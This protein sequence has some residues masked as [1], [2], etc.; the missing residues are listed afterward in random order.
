MS[1]DW[2]T[3]QFKNIA[4]ALSWQAEQQPHSIAIHYPQGGFM[5]P[6]KYTHKTYIE[7]NELSNVYARGLLEYGVESGTRTALMLTPGLDFIAM[8]FAMFKA[9]IIPVLVDPGIGIKPL[10]CCLEEAAPK[11]FIGITKAQLARKVLGWAKQSCRQFVTAG[12]TLGLGGI[13]LKTLRTLGNRSSGEILHLPDAEDMAA[14]LFTSGSTGIPKGVVYRHRHFSA[15]VE[16]LKQAFN[17]KPGEVGLPT[18]PPF[19]LFDPALGMTTVVPRMD[20][21]RPAKANPKVLVRTIDAF[22]VNNIFGSPALLNTLSR[23]LVD[24]NI[25]LKSVRRVISAGAAVPIRVIRR[26]EKALPDDAE[27]HTPYGA[28]ECLPVCSISGKQMTP[29]IQ[30]LS[31]SGNGICVGMPVAPNRV[32]IIA[33][34]EQAFSTLDQITEVAAGEPGEIIVSGPSCTDQYWKREQQ[35]TL[36]K[37]TDADGTI[38]HRMGDAGSLDNTGRL[39]YYGRVTQRLETTQEVLFA[40]RCEAVFNPHPELLRSALVGLGERGKQAPV[41]CVELKGKLNTAAKA[42]VSA[43]LLKIAQANSMTQSIQKVLFHKGFPVDIRHNSKINR[44][45]LAVWATGKI[46]GKV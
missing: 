28:T 1:T 14:I 41:L 25:E 26:M 44:E 13:N 36:A 39:W 3:G 30:A 22:Q 4:G 5:Q 19:A 46:G 6:H 16:M 20:P 32:K 23:Y 38:W 42:Q 40:D 18:F 33:I 24:S 12:P 31:T 34:S 7:L 21:T 8:F 27:I 2:S 45:Q 10:K 29:E 9:G 35:T 15:Q 17:I 37:I 11:A 43:D